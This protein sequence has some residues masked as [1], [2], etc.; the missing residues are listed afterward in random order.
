MKSKVADTPALG[1]DPP[2]VPED[3]RSHEN[4]QGSDREI[5]W[6]VVE[7]TAGITPA[8]IIANRLIYEG[9]PARARQEGAGQAIGLTV[10]LLGTG[11]VVVPEEFVDRAEKILSEPWDSGEMEDFLPEEDD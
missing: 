3:D 4:P 5:I 6:K 2:D 9:I 7:K 1:G 11:Y 10:G 8:T